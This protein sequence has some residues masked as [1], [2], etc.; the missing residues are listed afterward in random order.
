MEIAVSTQPPNE[1]QKKPPIPVPAKKVPAMNIERR[2]DRL[3]QGDGLHKWF[4]ISSLLL[5]LFTVLM[6]FID[7]SR[8]WK[9]YQRTFTRMQVQ[10]TQ[11][12]IAAAAGSFDR[13]KFDQLSQQLN[14]ARGEMQQ[15]EADVKAAQKKIDDIKAEY[16]RINQNYQFQKALY[17]TKKYE[18]DEAVAHKASNVDKLKAELDEDGKKMDEYK[19]DADRLKLDQRAAEA[20]LNKYVGARDTAQKGIET[21]ATD[22]N[23]L[24]VRRNSLNPG[25]MVTSF[26]N[27]PIFDML[28][29]SEKVQ[30]VILPNLYYD[31]P[32]KQIPRV[33]RCKTCHQGI[34]VKGFEQAPQ[35]FTTHP[36][37]DLYL[38]AS[39]PHPLENFGC[40][41]CHSGLDRAVDFNTAG[42]SPHDE[43]QREDW[44]RKYHWEEQEFLETPMLPMQQIEAG[45]YKCHNGTNEV[46]KAAALDSGR[47][48]IRIYGCFGCHKI[49]G[50]ETVRKVGPDL[51]TVSGKVTK[52]WARK[53]MANPREFKSEAR[54]PQFWWNSNNSGPDWD[55]RNV[56]EINA[57]SDYL[58]SKSKPQAL[59]AGRTN[60]DAAKGKQIVS[61]VG[62]FGCH[63]DGPL[64]DNPR[65]S[66]FR[67]KHGYSLQ[68]IGS[69][70]SAGWVYDWVK[71]PKQVW[72]Q[73]KMPSLRL[74]DDEAADIAAYLTSMK[75]PEFDSKPWPQTDAA[76][77]DSI[78]M[79]LLKGGSTEIE[80]REK[81][82]TM[83]PDQ[84][85]LF[86]GERLISRYGCFGCHNIPGF[87]TAQPIGTELSEAGS[88]MISQLDFGFLNIEHSRHA[89]YEQKLHDPRIFD[90][91]RV[92]RPEE[93]LRMPNFHFKDNEINSI[94]M[95]LTSMVK[96]K[97]ALEMRDRANQQIAAGRTLI[98]EK[99]CR[100]CHI[101][102]AQG[103]DIRALFSGTQLALAP[104]NLNTEGFKTQPL[105]L[106][107]F[108]IDPGRIKLRPWLDIRMPTF[109]FTDTEAA[110]IGAYFAAVDKV[111]YPYTSGEIDTT[112]EK[113]K[114]GAELFTKLQCASC[115]PTSTALPPGKEPSE[116][117]P[118]LLLASQR[119]RPDWVLMWIRN[120]QRIFPGTRMPSFFSHY[121]QPDYPDYLGGNPDAQIQALRDHLFLTVSGGKRTAAPVTTNNN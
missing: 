71:D 25:L 120:P 26:R 117:A 46:P 51:S 84:K 74:T 91:G 103:G 78:V 109:H 60:G 95:V 6:V 102:E 110:T 9:S 56:A 94:T 100:G 81:M 3:Y 2:G 15:H 73:T 24:L 77:L 67:R 96:D 111:S 62:C 17:D 101:I 119:L 63:T 54:M 98:A 59:P 87:E 57:I 58:F 13:A 61:S 48:L 104:P 114:V 105:W 14:Q 86:A 29:A 49:P 12:D 38:A 28:N 41:S 35:P 36:N 23:R 18:Y 44:K 65:Q 11:Q 10:Q 16:Y 32:F 7:Y 31:H 108:L 97:V 69:K 118:N 107:P 39:S 20:E 21:L 89:W 34:D 121:P 53:W 99:N 30:Q 76:T 45:C 52:D 40:T 1:A 82:N 22:Y 106:H 85:T 50:Y 43:K 90:V 70:L 115:H 68:A 92:K 4:A 112:P 55:K 93:L 83:T 42:H 47:D 72:P 8:E 80:A 5:F 27:A 37:L 64:Q 88:K 19:A 75:N 66:Q 79:E 33:D 116:L 113:L